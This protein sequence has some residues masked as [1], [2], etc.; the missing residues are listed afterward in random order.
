MYD[1]PPPWLFRRIPITNLFGSSV[2]IQPFVFTTLSI[3]SI[4]SV[5]LQRFVADRLLTIE[6]EQIQEAHNAAI[7]QVSCRRGEGVIGRVG[8]VTTGHT[9]T[10]ALKKWRWVKRDV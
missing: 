3:S 8:V 2:I 9:C 7:E 1:P 10:V 4:L 6:L 5:V